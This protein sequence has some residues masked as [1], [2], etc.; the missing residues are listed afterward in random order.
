MLPENVLPDESRYIPQPLMLFQIIFLA[1]FHPRARLFVD[2]KSM[3][4][5]MP[6]L[7]VYLGQPPSAKVDGLWANTPV[8]SIRTTI[9]IDTDD[10]LK[11]PQLLEQ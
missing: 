8:L 5:I 3:T 11:Q 2:K 9:C 4:R 6:C 10:L 7:T 1:A